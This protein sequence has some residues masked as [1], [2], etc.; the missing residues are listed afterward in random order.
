MTCTGL[1]QIVTLCLCGEKPAA[2]CASAEVRCAYRAACSPV[3]RTSSSC[4]AIGSA[5]AS[6][7]IGRVASFSKPYQLGPAA[8]SALSFARSEMRAWLSVCHFSAQNISAI[9]MTLE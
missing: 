4:A 2:S 6:F 7:A 9:L 8:L 1:P 3:R 5:H